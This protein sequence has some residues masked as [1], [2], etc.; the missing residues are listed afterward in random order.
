LNEE[1]HDDLEGEFVYFG[2]CAVGAAPVD[3]DA[4]IE[5][6]GQQLR[7]WGLVK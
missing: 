3:F 6:V 1:V 4:V 7:D 2:S 5:F